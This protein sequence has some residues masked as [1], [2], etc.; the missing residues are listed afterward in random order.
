MDKTT[1][2]FHPVNLIQFPK[3]FVDS[4]QPSFLYTYYNY[5]NSSQTI[6]ILCCSKIHTKHIVK[7][8]LQNII[9]KM[10]DLV[11]AKSIFIHR[12]QATNL[13]T[14]LVTSVKIKS[15]ASGKK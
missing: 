4:I 15:F 5:Y 12:L 6:H 11:F 1:S 2:K 10:Y 7:L 8:F 9:Y 3:K 14:E 13:N